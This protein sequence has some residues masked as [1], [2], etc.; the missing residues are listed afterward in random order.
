[1]EFKNVLLRM[2]GF[3]RSGHIFS[4]KHVLYDI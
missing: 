3:R 4:L 1:M 2:S